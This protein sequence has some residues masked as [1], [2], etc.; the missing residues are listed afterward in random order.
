M[1]GGIY[2][3][4]QESPLFSKAV[5][6]Q[7][8]LFAACFYRSAI[9]I[10]FNTCCGNQRRNDGYPSIFTTLPLSQGVINRRINIF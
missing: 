7:S 6:K 4:A 9:N 5:R 10:T 1:S 3:L 8:P 2:L